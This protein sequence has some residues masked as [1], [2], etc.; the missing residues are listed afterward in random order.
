MTGEGEILPSGAHEGEEIDARMVEEAPVLKCEGCAHHP[1]GQ[2]LNWPVAVVKLPATGNETVLDAVAQVNGLIAVS[3]AHRIWVARPGPDGCE[4]VLPVDWNGITACGKTGTNYQILPGDRVYVKAY[5]LVT[6]D[7]TL[8][9]VFAPIERVLGIALLGNSTARAF[10]PRG[11]S[12]GG[13][14]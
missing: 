8:A 2:I 14:P 12:N 13:V 10:G 4:S 6:A 7:T 3:D 9:R 11:G 1:V 5:P